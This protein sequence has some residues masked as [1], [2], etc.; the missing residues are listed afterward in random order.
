[1]RAP[2]RPARCVMPAAWPTGCAPPG[3]RSMSKPAP[4]ARPNAIASPRPC[5]WPNAWARFRRPCPP[6]AKRTASS[7]S[8]A[9]TMSPISSRW[10]RRR[11]GGTLCGR[12][13]P[14]RSS[15]A[16]ATSVCMS[17][18]PP[19]R[20]VGKRPRSPPRR[21]R[22]APNWNRALLSAACCSAPPGWALRFCC[23]RAWG[24][25]MSRWCCWSRFWPAPSPSA[26]G[27]RCS[28]AWYRRWP[29]ISS[30]CRRSTPSPSPSRRMSS[31]CWCSCW[32]RPS[33]AT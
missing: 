3:R 6:P 5:A 26:C 32:S 16:P 13:W 17:C 31:P 8:P 21:G 29:I 25:R 14:G 22:Q 28:P 2:A 18:R 33:P 11:A 4:P 12:P 20:A 9:P 19:R 23:A 24:C 30:S 7:P 10:D 1:M 15:A 27:P